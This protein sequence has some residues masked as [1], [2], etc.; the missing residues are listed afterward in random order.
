MGFLDWMS[1][2]GSSVIVDLD[3]A[4]FTVAPKGA[5]KELSKYHDRV[6]QH[7]AN[8][9]AMALTTIQAAD[10]AARYYQDTDGK[11]NLLKPRAALVSN[12]QIL[13]QIT[14]AVIQLQKAGRQGEAPGFHLW[15]FTLRAV[16]MPEQQPR[17][18][19][20]WTLIQKAGFLYWSEV[21]ATYSSICGVPLAK[22][23][24]L[25]RRIPEGFGDEN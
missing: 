10:V 20:I 24:L 18:K 22:D 1:G 5:M 4:K 15:G 6:L 9:S 13:W 16:L 2:P 25:F 12:P 11:T 21:E 3:G 8:K 7:S 14:E 17:M 23:N 19:E